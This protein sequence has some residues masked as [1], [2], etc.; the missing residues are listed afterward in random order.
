MI[1]HIGGPR[2]ESW[3]LRGPSYWMFIEVLASIYSESYMV[4]NV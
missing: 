4:G 3:E 2:F 1:S